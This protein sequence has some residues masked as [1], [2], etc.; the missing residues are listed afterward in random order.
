MYELGWTSAAN[1]SFTLLLHYGFGFLGF[2]FLLEIR[3]QQIP[4]IHCYTILVDL[5]VEWFMLQVAEIAEISSV[6][7]WDEII[8]Q[9]EAA[10]GNSYLNKYFIVLYK[11]L[12]TPSFPIKTHSTQS[13]NCSIFRVVVLRRLSVHCHTWRDKNNSTTLCCFCESIFPKIYLWFASEPARVFFSK[14]YKCSSLSWSTTD[15]QLHDILEL[16]MVLAR[17]KK[18]LARATQNKINFK[19]SMTNLFYCHIL[20]YCLHLIKLISD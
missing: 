19:L 20:K 9:S 13:T 3:V 7:M 14:R 18:S 11:N 2:S 10:Q 12:D 16:Y 17:N 5:C 6:R 8:H 4:Q 1:L 15:L